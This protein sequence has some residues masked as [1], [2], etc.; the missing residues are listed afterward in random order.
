ME[1]KISFLNSCDV[2]RAQCVGGSCNCCSLKLNLMF[3]GQWGLSVKCALPGF[4][5]LD[6]A[7]Q[8]MGFIWSPPS[9]QIPAHA[10]A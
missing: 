1:C 2:S 9:Q 6:L 3:S 4:D 10:E 7:T 8:T 5:Y